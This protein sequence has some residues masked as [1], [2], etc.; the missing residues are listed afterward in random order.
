[1]NPQQESFLLEKR[2]R[3]YRAIIRAAA[4][5]SG[6]R[7]ELLHAVIAV[8]SGF[9]PRA[10]SPKGAMGLMQLMPA[11]A[12]ELG[13]DHP[14]DPEENVLGGARHLRRLVDRFDG[15]LELALA[16]YNAG[17]GRVRSTGRI[18]AIPETR[19]YV[20]RVLARMGGWRPS[21]PRPGR[22]TGRTSP[23][24]EPALYYH[25]DPNGVTSFTDAPRDD[26]RPIR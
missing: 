11:T 3:P 4:V 18:P 20:R 22:T 1:L 17:E 8:E 9:Q 14:F 16:A 24:P 19:Q 23:E 15:D 13:V 12:A 21:P 6:L 5:E 25:V 10:V 26:H 7:E 2:A